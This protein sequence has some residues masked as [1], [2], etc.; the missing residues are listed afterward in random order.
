MAARTCGKSATYGPPAFFETEYL[1]VWARACADQEH[2]SVRQAK[3]LRERPGDQIRL[4]VTALAFPLPV[5]RY[6]NYDVS[7]HPFLARDYAE[8]IC[9]PSAQRLNLIEL[10]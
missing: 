5:E 3:L 10:Q 9:E 6:W 2:S 8:L 4:I 7:F 1:L